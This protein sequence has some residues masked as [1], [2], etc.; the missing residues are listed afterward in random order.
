MHWG[1]KIQRSRH[2]SRLWMQLGLRQHLFW[3]VVTNTCSELWLLPYKPAFKTTRILTPVQRKVDVHE[4][5]ELF[6]IL[7]D[8][9]GEVSR[10]HFRVCE[11]AIFCC[12]LVFFFDL[13]WRV[14]TVKV[15][16]WRTHHLEQ[17]VLVPVFVLPHTIWK[18]LRGRLPFFLVVKVPRSLWMSSSMGSC[19]ANHLHLRNCIFFVFCC[20]WHLVSN[21]LRHRQRQCIA[22]SMWKA[23]SNAC[24]FPDTLKV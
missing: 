21:L 15:F 6:G 19:D 17:F 13:S 4:G 23:F 9:D 3:V 7:D 1:F 8:G 20:V 5:T 12:H 10:L 22:I 14:G 2:I 16:D 24:H 18:W 11:L